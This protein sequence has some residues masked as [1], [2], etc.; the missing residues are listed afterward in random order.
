MQTVRR[1]A[2]V[3]NRNTEAKTQGGNKKGWRKKQHKR[4]E[5]A[6]QNLKESH[7]KAIEETSKKHE[8][9][10]QQL[11]E[12]ANARTEKAIDTKVAGTLP[13]PKENTTP[14]D[15]ASWRE[16]LMAHAG[17]A[18]SA[19]TSTATGTIQWISDYTTLYG[20]MLSPWKEIK[21]CCK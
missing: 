8:S 4:H 14:A 20:L 7:E 21:T 15:F 13:K 1:I 18:R 3:K 6:T 2:E 17:L 11:G 10:Q 5:E 12:G 16:L 19:A 9:L